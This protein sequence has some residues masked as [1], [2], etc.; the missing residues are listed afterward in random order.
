MPAAET[1]TTPELPAEEESAFA[2]LRRL[3]YRVTASWIPKDRL[4]A[5]GDRLRTARSVVGF[6]LLLL[7][8][9]FEAWLFFHWVLPPAAT[10]PLDASLVFGLALLLGVPAALRRDDLPELAANLVV[11]ASFAVL[12]AVFVLLGGIRA[13]VLHWCALVPMLA[14]LM[15]ARRSAWVWSGIAAVTLGAFAWIEVAG[16]PLPSHL[17]AS[18]L[19]GHRLWIQRLVD[20]GS[21]IAMLLGVALIYERHK[22]QQTAELGTT[23][24]E[25]TRE[26][27]QRRRAE[28]RTRYLAYHDE[29]TELPNR[30]FFQEQLEDA[31]VQAERDGRLV[32]VMFMD[33][34]GFKEVNDTY[35]HR[36]GDV[37]LQQVAER[38]RGCVRNADAVFQGG[39]GEPDPAEIPGEA[40]GETLVSRLGGDE[41]T[42]L[43][44]RLRDKREAGIVARRVLGSLE[45]PF[46]LEGHEVHISASIGIALHPGESDDVGGLLKNADLAMYAAKAHGKN[47]YQFF[48]EAMNAEIV[49]RTTVAG[50]LRHALERDELCVYYQPIVRTTDLAIVGLEALVR[51]QHPTRGLVPPGEFIGIA[52]ATGL[53]V[54]ISEV[55]LRRACRQVRLFREA[56]LPPV[57]MSV[58]LSG[59]QLRHGG[60]AGQV[61]AV[62]AASGIR[63][64]DLELEVTESAVMVD[65]DEAALSLSE[66]KQLGV[67]VALDDFGT[68]YSSLSYIQRYPVDQLKID[69]SFVRDVASDPDAQAITKAIVAMA[70]GLSLTVVAEG[71]ETEAQELFLKAL[72][73]DFL[74][75]FRFSVPVPADEMARILEQGVVPEDFGTRRGPASGTG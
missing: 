19:T 54:P 28:Q 56:G 17:E 22:D 67:G 61:R 46:P 52:E 51:W 45:A 72:G 24:A 68:G 15:G 74:Q 75:G 42:L 6:T 18:G 53:I 36:L 35:G 39:P 14:V 31:M 27:A 38:L 63:P 47:N 23:N 30:Q 57:R 10:P 58:N 62:L 50:E 71:V 11:A 33:L 70:H 29:L 3:Y 7:V 21:W 4:A 20:V 5:G 12:V 16:A 69:R 13:P 48:S 43:L 9:A 60:V 65:E 73:C 55:V 40:F 1:V 2:R 32:G 41:F 25:L 34:D 59:V 66:L 44:V 64:E 8:L 49:H 26:V 37:L